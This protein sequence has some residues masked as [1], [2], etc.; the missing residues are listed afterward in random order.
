MSI[1]NTVRALRERM[2]IFHSRHDEKGS[3]DVMTFNNP[4]FGWQRAVWPNGNVVKWRKV[5]FF[6][7]D[8]DADFNKAWLSDSDDD[9]KPW[10][11][12]AAAGSSW[13]SAP[14]SESSE[15]CHYQQASTWQ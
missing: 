14:L 6:W 3:Y 10:E 8:E 9:N 7:E 13:D 1:P 4:G 5:Q 12:S 15:I 11:D 2:L